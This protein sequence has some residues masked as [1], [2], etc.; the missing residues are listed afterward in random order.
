MVVMACKQHTE[1]GGDYDSAH[2]KGAVGPLRITD[3]QMDSMKASS[4]HLTPAKAKPLRA[5][6]FLQIWP[7]NQGSPLDGHRPREVSA[8]HLAGLSQLEAQAGLIRRAYP[9][10]REAQSSA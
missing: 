5:Q 2:G 4:T 9:M 7:P 3:G 10:R 1:D 6:M 8:P